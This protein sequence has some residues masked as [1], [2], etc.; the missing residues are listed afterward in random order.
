MPVQSMIPLMFLAIAWVFHPALVHFAQPVH[1]QHT[2]GSGFFSGLLRGWLTLYLAFSFML[3]WN[4]IAM[5]AA[6]CHIGETRN[7]EHEAKIAM[8]LEGLYGTFI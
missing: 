4:E 6:A 3:T 5:E 7:P 8:N 1:L 2:N